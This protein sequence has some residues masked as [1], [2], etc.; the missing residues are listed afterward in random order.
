MSWRDNIRSWCQFS[1]VKRERGNPVLYSPAAI[2]DGV[3]DVRSGTWA[4]I[5]NRLNAE[6]VK[7]REANDSIRRNEVQTAEIRGRIG[8]IKE[9]LELPTIDGKKQS[10]KQNRD[11]DDYDY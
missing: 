8:M 3:L 2:D 11:L 7:A 1:R 5:R 10:K 4:F 9:L 6:L